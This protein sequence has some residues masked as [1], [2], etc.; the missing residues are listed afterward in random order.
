MADV[1]RSGAA[2]L[3]DQLAASAGATV[4]YRRGA[5]VAT[6]TAVVGRS[7]FESQDQ[8]GVSES[9]ESR[10]YIIKTADFPHSEPLRGDRIVETLGSDSIVFEVVSPR[11]VP[12]FHHGDPF[13]STIR[14]HTKRV[15]VTT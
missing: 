9:W 15:G 2:W 12:L 13:H 5:N 4:E 10:D 1:I 3:A 7:V 8:S 11:G 14:V 6:I